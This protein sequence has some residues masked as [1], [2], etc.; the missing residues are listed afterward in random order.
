MRI[1]LGL[2]YDGSEFSGWQSQ[3]SG[4]T[5][6]DTLESSISVI[7]GERV[8]TV[9]A[10]RT[11]TGVH[12]TGQ[13]VHFDVS[14]DRPMSAW[15]RGVNAHLSQSIAVRWAVPVPDGFH[16]R[17]AAKS[18][19]YRYILLNR[20]ERPGLYNGSVGWC[21]RILDVDAMQ[22]AAE[23]LV[24]EHDFTSFRA[25]GCQALSPIKTLYRFT[26]VRRGDFVICECTGNSFLHHMVRNLV[27]ALVYVGTGRENPAW[28]SCLLAAKDR[29]MGAPTFAPG[30]L[31]LTHVDYES[32]W[33][34]PDQRGISSTLP[35]I[36]L[37]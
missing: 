35:L 2:E 7:A 24:G 17:F 31:Y 8:R 32:L 13:V 10:G 19:S 6:Q 30:G 28:L 14:V 23:C 36:G 29:R 21:H 1:A 3:R 33:G 26:V 15:I 22:V 20:R 25:S 11:D 27:G 9:C 18:R 37:N 16:A 12:A 5:V 4:N 34:L